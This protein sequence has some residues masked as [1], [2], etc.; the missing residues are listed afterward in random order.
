MF[1][2]ALDVPYFFKFNRLGYSLFIF[3]S[4][5]NFLTGEAANF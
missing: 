3:E 2:Y 1:G 5:N 4:Y